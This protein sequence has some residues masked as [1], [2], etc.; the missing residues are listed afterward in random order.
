MRRFSCGLACGYAETVDLISDGTSR[1]AAKA[2]VDSVWRSEAVPR[3]D[4]YRVTVTADNGNVTTW[5]VH[6]EGIEL[7]L[8]AMAVR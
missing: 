8:T 2:F 1:E 3:E 5:D 4:E 7:D 6:V